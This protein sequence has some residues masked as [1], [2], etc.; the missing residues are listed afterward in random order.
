MFEVV[1]NLMKVYNGNEKIY[2]FEVTGELC[3][4]CLLTLSKLEVKLNR[5]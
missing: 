4:F 5:F 2:K 3:T 1:C